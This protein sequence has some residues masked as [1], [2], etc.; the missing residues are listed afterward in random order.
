MG[1]EAAIRWGDGVTVTFRAAAEP[2]TSRRDYWQHVVGTAMGPV[3]L[4][5]DGAVG[6]RD[7]LVVADLGAVR[8]GA[9]E[10]SYP[11]GASRRDR[12]I[13][14]ADPDLCKIDVVVQGRGVV[15]QDGR[16][17]HLREGD[18]TFVD[19]SRPGRWRMSASRLI[20]VIFPRAL[21]P[22]RRAD[23]GRLTAVRIPG[24]RGAGAVVSALARSVVA[25]AGEADA[26]LGTAVLDLFTTALAA[27]LDRPVPPATR[28][29]AMFL[30]VQA[31]IERNLG[32]PGLSPRSIAD[33]HFISVRHL[34]KLFEGQESTVAGW[35]RAR[36]L[37]RC[38]RDLLDPGLRDRTVAAIGARW[39]LTNAAHFS[40]AFRAAYGLPPVEFRA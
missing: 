13:R 39:G 6:E 1:R 23:A 22:L 31:Y 14:Q 37:D 10:A 28:Q 16:E 29:R 11:G 34:H 15:E 38:R 12:H 8:V 25:H 35:I 19:L 27:R 4:Q 36:R 18:L 26:R 32:D 7:R 17:A 2:A 40:R 33:A 9:L 20:A 3:D 24:D 21:L 30:R 5:V